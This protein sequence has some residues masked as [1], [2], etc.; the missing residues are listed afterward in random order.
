MAAE[1]QDSVSCDRP[2]TKSEI[3]FQEKIKSTKFALSVGIIAVVTTLVTNGVI[4][5]IIFSDIVQLVVGA[6]ILGD[7]AQNSFVK[8]RWSK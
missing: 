7:V 5:P 2:M 6:Y 4:T 3:K 8:S 1:N